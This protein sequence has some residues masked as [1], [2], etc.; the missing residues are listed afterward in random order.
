MAEKTMSGIIIGGIF[1]TIIFAAF[2]LM[3]SDG[4]TMYT[5]SDYNDSSLKAFN[6]SITSFEETT[7]ATKDALTELQGSPDLSDILGAVFV[8]AFGALSTLGNSFN[9]FFTLI[10]GGIPLL[11]TGA[12]G[13]IIIMVL[14]T[15]LV[16][17]IIKYL[18]DY[19]RPGTKV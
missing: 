18:L 5:V 19:L 1:L 9:V 4:I 17:V 3:Y 6:D 7:A 14:S 15:A 8:S 10:T 12:L 16:V 13:G 2:I 11:P